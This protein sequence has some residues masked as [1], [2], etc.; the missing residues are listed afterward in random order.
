[1]PSDIEHNYSVQKYIADYEVIKKY[2]YDINP[3]SYISVPTESVRLKDFILKLNR[4]RVL[5]ADE[6]EE[7][8]SDM[9]TR[10]KYLK[11]SDICDGIISGDLTSLKYIPENM[12]A[13]TLKE[14]SIVLSKS[15]K[16]G[17]AAV[18][19]HIGDKEIIAEQNLIVLEVD[20]ERI[21]P[22]FLAAYLNIEEYPKLRKI[23]KQLSFPKIKNIV[24]SMPKDKTTQIAWG[25]TYKNKL[26]ALKKAYI[27]VDKAVKDIYE[28]NEWFNL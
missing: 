28:D 16:R 6:L 26:F 1:L 15:L 10:F 25:N 14:N 3:Y 2:H 12:R 24:V 5:N 19:N 9:N 21:D 22:W 11:Q 4:G 8:K 27:G 18:I 17:F 20:T 7:Y 23:T 13:Y